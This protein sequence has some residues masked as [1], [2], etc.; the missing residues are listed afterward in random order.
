[1]LVETKA[2]SYATPERL[3]TIGPNRS[4]DG[5]GDRVTLVLAGRTSAPARRLMREEGIGYFDAT[6][7]ELYLRGGGLRIDAVTPGATSPSQARPAPGVKGLAA[8]TMA[9]ELLRRAFDGDHRP[10]GVRPATDELGLARSSISDARQ[11]LVG[12]GLVTEDDE[13][14]LPSLFWELALSWAPKERRWLAEIPDPGEWN[15]LAD[16]ASGEWRLGGLSAAVALGA[17]GVGVGEAP[18]DLYVPGP[19]LLTIAERRYGTADV[20]SARAS[21]AVPAVSQVTSVPAPGA[22]LP[23]I[24]RGWPVVHPVA[25]ALDL[26]SLGDARARQILEEWE[27]DGN[28]VWRER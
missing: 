11:R 24:V 27:P 3:T 16:S 1:V 7:G 8:T 26:A 6:T 20:L 28:V 14:T 21:V 13:P 17:P 25:A 18:L 12:A 10:L 23:V 15:A 9:Y 5:S 4:V 19:V 22:R 2:I